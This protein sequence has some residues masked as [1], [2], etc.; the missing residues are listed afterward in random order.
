MKNS[1]YLA[2]LILSILL[3]S[4]FFGAASA[5]RM[6]VDVMEIEPKIV[7][8]AYYG[9]GTPVK[10]ADVTVYLPNED[11]YLA[12][13]T[14][15]NGCFSF[16]PPANKEYI[17]VVVE[18]IGHRAEKTINLTEI[19]SE[20]DEGIPIYLGLIIGVSILAAVGLVSF[21]ISKRSKKT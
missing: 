11:V 5:H 18:Q 9:D 17:V 4:V 2:F 12:G 20:E 15:S 8:E 16:D 3:I 6:Y 19:V 10:N 21:R 14:D 7:I 13:K 1:S